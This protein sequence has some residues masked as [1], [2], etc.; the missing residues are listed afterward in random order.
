MS[1]LKSIYCLV[2]TCVQGMCVITYISLIPGM[3]WK[4]DLSSGCSCRKCWLWWN[5]S[6]NIHRWVVLRLWHFII[7]ITITIIIIFIIIYQGRGESLQCTLL[8]V[9]QKLHHSSR[10]LLHRV[11]LNEYVRLYSLIACCDLLYVP[12]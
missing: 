7:L 9:K 4:C 1:L 8:S 12:V 6:I 2:S 3:Q 5:C 11:T 10:A